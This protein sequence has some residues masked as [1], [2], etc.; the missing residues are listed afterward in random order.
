MEKRLTHYA[1]ALAKI[2]IVQ[3]LD[4]KHANPCS[5]SWFYDFDLNK[6]ELA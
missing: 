1:K 2:F 3:A 6:K 4:Y 5:S